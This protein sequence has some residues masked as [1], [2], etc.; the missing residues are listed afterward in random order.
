M[1]LHVLIGCQV[2]IFTEHISHNLIDKCGRSIVFTLSSL[3]LKR[4][5]I[6]TILKHITPIELVA[7]FI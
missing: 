3:Q 1:M 6:I 2:E 5:Y 4:I 7:L